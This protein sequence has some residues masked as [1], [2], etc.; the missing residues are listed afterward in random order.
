MAGPLAI[1]KRLENLGRLVENG[2]LVLLLTTMIVLAAG[3]IILRNFFDVG[4]VW[5]DEFLRVCLLWTALFG[6][7]AASRANKQISI[8]VLSRFLKGRW[9]ALAA[10]LVQVFTASITGVMAWHS[11]RFVRD[12]KIY[13]DVLM[14]DWPAWVFQSVLPLAF[15]LIA[16]RYSVFAIASALRLARGER[17]V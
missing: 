3:Q 2:I 5:A 1:L 15:A 12:S 10:M 7:V 17:S 8:D 16:Y 6:A 4:F 13:E 14:G 11:F 9:N